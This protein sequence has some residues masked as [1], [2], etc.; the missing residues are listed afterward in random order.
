VQV[1]D[2]EHMSADVRITIQDDESML[3]AVQ[4]EVSLIVLRVARHPAKHAT[5]AVWFSA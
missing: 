1:R 3:G 4:Y 5:L 2:D